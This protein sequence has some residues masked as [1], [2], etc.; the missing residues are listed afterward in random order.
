M[1]QPKLNK[2]VHFGSANHGMF[3]A[4]SNLATED[5]ET[6]DGIQ[7]VARD[8][9]D[10]KEILVFTDLRYKVADVQRAIMELAEEKAGA[11]GENV[12]VED[13]QVDTDTFSNTVRASFIVEGDCLSIS[14]I[15]ALAGVHSTYRICMSNQVRVRVSLLS[16]VRI[17]KERI[18]R[19]IEKKQA[20][21]EMSIK[22]T[23]GGKIEIENTCLSMDE[24]FLV[25]GI[26]SVQQRTA[27][28]Y[29]ASICSHCGISS[30]ADRV[31]DAEKEKQDA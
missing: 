23:S 21:K 6:I 1:K 30:T 27:N 17:V 9:V 19:A 15:F 4:T 18:K 16:T 10:S 25:T 12:V 2:F 28:S 5:L 31:R 13:N 22:I 20:K 24:I 7:R 29:T 8:R 11:A 14:E 26:Q 3:S